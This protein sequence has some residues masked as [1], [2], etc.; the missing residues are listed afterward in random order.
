[1]KSLKLNQLKLN[2][3]TNKEMEILAGGQQ[4]CCSCGCGCCY[5][6]TPGGSSSSDNSWANGN[7]AEA[8][9]GTVTS[10]C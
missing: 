2:G 8:A 6:G 3:I 5:A 9:G 4:K 1:M 7:M 10:P